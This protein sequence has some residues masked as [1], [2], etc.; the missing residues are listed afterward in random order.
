MGII[1]NNRNMPPKPVG[2]MRT[3]WDKP[4]Y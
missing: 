2:R 3:K 4:T 1:N